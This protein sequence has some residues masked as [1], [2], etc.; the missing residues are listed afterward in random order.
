MNSGITAFGEFFETP[1]RFHCLI[2]I[3]REFFQ[4]HKSIRLAPIEFVSLPRK[5]SQ[6]GY[7]FLR[8]RLFKY[9]SWVK[10]VASILL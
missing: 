10:S 1:Q 4:H 6:T 5:T 8:V 7:A 9:S 2:L 3:L